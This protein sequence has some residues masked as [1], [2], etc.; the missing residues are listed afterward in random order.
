M[1][2]NPYGRHGKILFLAIETDPDR[3]HQ[4]A[5]QSDLNS[6][7]ARTKPVLVPHS[8][9]VSLHFVCCYL[10]IVDRSFVLRMINMDTE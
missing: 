4:F 6:Q 9:R 10:P 1:N 2:D 3:V 7:P 8:F 5:L